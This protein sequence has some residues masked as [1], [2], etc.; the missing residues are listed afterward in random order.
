M[1]LD[2]FDILEALLQPVAVVNAAL[3]V[4]FG[5]QAFYKDLNCQAALTQKEVIHRLQ[6][7]FQKSNLPSELSLTNYPTLDQ[8]L[9]IDCNLLENGATV[10]NYVLMFR[11]SHL[12]PPINDV[13]KYTVE[14]SANLILI[15]NLS[16]EIIF[17]SKA[18]KTILGYEI[19]EI[20]G[21]N[22]PDFVHPSE[23]DT[24]KDFIK[25]CL[26]QRPTEAKFEFKGIHKSGKNIWLRTTVRTTYD[27]ANKVIGFQSSLQ[28]IT[29]QKEYESQLIKSRTQYQYLFENNPNPLLIVEL[30]TGKVLKINL[31]ATQMYGYPETALLN[32]PLQQLTSPSS[33]PAFYKI[34]KKNHNKKYYQILETAQ[35]RSNGEEF[36]A[37]YYG[38]KLVY[39]EKDCDLILVVDVTYQVIVEKSIKE[40]LQE[41]QRISEELRA[42]EEELKQSIDAYHEINQQLQESEA[43]FRNLSQNAPIGIYLTDTEGNCIWV[44]KMMQK[45][46]DFDLHLPLMSQWL[47][48]LHPA[49]YQQARE[50]WRRNASE[51]AAHTQEYRI[52]VNGTTKWVKTIYAPMF[53]EANQLLGFLGSLEDRTEVKNIAEKEAYHTEFRE[54]LIQIL[55]GF[56]N[57]DVDE[58]EKHVGTVLKK[59]ADFVNYD[60]IRI[61]GLSEDKTQAQVRFQYIAPDTPPVL[62]A[63]KTFNLQQWAWWAVQIQQNKT[64]EINDFEQLPPEAA[65]EKEQLINARIK[66]LF[67]VPMF[68]QAQLYGYITFSSTQEQVILSNDSKHIL[69]LLAQTFANLLNRITINQQLK[70]SQNLY[71]LLA[72]NITDLITLH[73]TSLNYLY[74]SPSMTPML[75]YQVE[76]LLGVTSMQFVHPEDTHLIE[77]KL[78]ETV[79]GAATR[80]TYRFLHKEGHYV[81][82]ESNG[83]VITDPHTNEIKLLILNRDVTQRIEVTQA[84]RSSQALLATIFDESTDAILI[85]NEK[86]LIENCNQRTLELF[87]AK[88][89]SELIGQSGFQFEVNANTYQEFSELNAAIAKKSII[90]RKV[91]YKTCKGNYFWANFAAKKLKIEGKNKILVTLT[92]ITLLQQANRRIAVLLKNAQT[93]NEQLTQQNEQLLQANQE[94]DNF[95]YSV[96]HDLRAPLT[97]A[98]GLITISKEEKNL[99]VILTY[100][101]LQEKSLKKLDRFIHEIVDYSRNSRLAIEPQ[102][103][104]FGQIIQDTFEQLRFMEQETQIKKIID[105]SSE[106]RLYSDA[107]R[108]GIIFS[109]LISNAIRYSDPLKQEC[110]IKIEITQ[111]EGQV[112]ISVADNG[113]GIAE[114]HLHRIFDMFYRA[115][116]NKP[117]SGLGLYILKEALK[118]IKG[119]IEVHSKQGEGTTFTLYLPNLK[120][121]E[122]QG[123]DE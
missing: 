32:A 44:N 82:I 12:S 110:F 63:H 46:F 98:M 106:V 49:D 1:Q 51:K 30:A 91:Q 76:E 15:H 40:R 23:K 10:A 69:R 62:G 14:N 120:A 85:V 45:I 25:M 94:L 89:K 13:F 112:V 92:D 57:A 113:Q 34:W 105:I 79:S 74:I 81:W 84:L 111:K 17:L 54:L 119:R 88:E 47:N 19:N 29:A 102:Q 8:Q 16:G 122:P 64:I 43:R 41:E 35:Q 36:Y 99:A 107:G 33:I 55:G 87:E 116:D 5:N 114:G 77:A 22:I 115:T 118:K 80:I 72:D 53:N 7:I 27:A 9:T 28:D 42:S 97:S 103:I 50:V 20:K 75:G 117:G 18:F 78:T 48:T 39:E 58:L 38:H 4:V 95:V 66:S 101:E 100:L 121:D 61:F 73:D 56:I 104:D 6:H 108:L 59:I 11:L 65:Y 67:V 21:R 52:I 37:N 96:S 60:R 90:H 2:Y 24:A 123:K 109:N 71:R 86:D 3:E 26:T 83:K 68:F 31:A 93:L 70:E